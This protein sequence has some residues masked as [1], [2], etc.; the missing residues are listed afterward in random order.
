MAR[1]T[2]RLGGIG[3]VAAAAIAMAGCGSGASTSVE[4]DTLKFAVVAEETGAFGAYGS[5]LVAGVKAAVEDLNASGDYEFELEPVFYDCQSD[6]AICVSKTRQAI[7]TDK[8]PLVIGPIVSLDVLPAAEVTERQGVP[9][10]V[11]TVTPL[12][13]EDYSNTFR[14][15]TQND[16]LNQTVVDYVKA[17]LK[18][19]EEVAI[20]HANTDFGQGGADIQEAQLEAAGIT[21]VAVIGHDPDQAD[22][23]PL[24]VDLKKANPRYVL[25]SDSNPADVAKLL[26]QAKE[27]NLAA[28]WI[29]ADAAGSIELAGDAATGY[30][31]VSPW[32][33]N[34]AA[35]PNSSELTKKFQEQGV[36]APGWIS[37]MSYVA[38]TG[39]AEA[40]AA[41]GGFTPEGLTEGLQSLNEMEG[42]AA[43]S[44]TFT[45][46]DHTGL[47]TA[48]IALWNGTAY[49]TVWPQD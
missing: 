4:G 39:V 10:I 3:V 41:A 38:T 28:E 33:P 46:D 23:T 24:M 37:A 27:T 47:R 13:T 11:M 45:A 6:Q 44:W 21:P 17:N 32:F 48:T 35:D 5:E 49:E 16:R 34:N 1:S 30:M 25:L 26:R 31:T 42:M 19:G 43:S 20:V 7:T 9:H 12:I 22:Y 15:S 2:N 40:A 14:F 18:A 29:G 36:D 8:L